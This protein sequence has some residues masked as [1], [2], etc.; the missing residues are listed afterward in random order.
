MNNIYG[1]PV[2]V[3]FGVGAGLLA[4][5]VAYALNPRPE[6]KSKVAGL[7]GT[8]VGLLVAGAAVLWIR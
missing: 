7:V 2:P 5:G 1:I 8:G 6:T 3:L 4:G